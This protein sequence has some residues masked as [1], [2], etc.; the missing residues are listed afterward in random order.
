MNPTAYLAKIINQE[1]HQLWNWLPAIFAFGVIFYINLQ[2][3]FLDHV[4][5][6]LAIF[7]TSAILAYLNRA[8]YRSF[9]FLSL[10]LFL[11]A[12][13]YSNFY[14]KIFL[15]HTEISGKAYVDGI[16]KVEEIN[17]FYNPVSHLTGASLL[18]KDPVLY[19]MQFGEKKVEKP[20]IIKKKKFTS[21][22]KKKFSKTIH[23]KYAN[24]NGYQDLDRK[25]F[26]FSTNYQN[27][28]WVDSKGRK[29]FPNPPKKLLINIVKY[30]DDIKINDVIALKLSLNPS[31]KGEFPDDF[32]F[33]L[34]A[35]AKQI[36]GYG[37]GF[38][39]IKIV[40]KAEISSLDEFFISLRQSAKDKIF[41]ATDGD[42]AA[43]ISALLIGDQKDISLTLMKDIRGSGLAHLL[44]ISGFHLSLMAM[45]FLVGARFLLSRSEYLALNFDLKKISAIGAI[46]TTYFYLKIS[47]SPLPAQRS[48]L[49][50]LFF[51]ISIFV[52]QKLN[53]KRTIMAALFLMI[54]A[55]PYNIFNVGFQL[56][57]A[58]IL[59]LGAFSD[60]FGFLIK[61]E[62]DQSF[63]SKAFYYFITIVLTSIAIQIATTPFLM[64][65][66]KN[67]SVLGFIANIL[68]IPLASF[69]VM[70]VGFL[71]L[72]LMPFSLEKYVLILMKQG[73]VLIAKISTFVANLDY[74]YFISPQLSGIGL[75]LAVAGLFMIC[76]SESQL[77]FWGIAIFLS[78]FLTLSFAQKPDISFQ[79]KQKFFTIYDEKNGLIF[80]KDL[81]PSKNRDL[82]LKYF[83]QK[84]FKSYTDLTLEEKK[85]RGIFCKKESC[86]AEIKGKIFL[87]LLERTKVSEICVNNFDIIVNLTSKYELPTCVKDDKMKIDNLNFYQNGGQF[88]YFRNGGF[89]VK[90]S[91]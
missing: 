84:D 72:F 19:Q 69:F 88:F 31:R 64:Y 40:K 33:D 24:I 13:F 7:F 37:Y 44:S 17:K 30:A 2:Q 63:L 48:F 59:V 68:A 15:N 75:V 43:I 50:V 57:F 62:P 61:K 91:Y 38:G 8:S 85:E 26:D 89:E 5:I 41:K 90:S 29:Q 20:K 83:N 32:N 4:L 25:F 79:S 58:A 52:S 34:N 60:N 81:R 35:K 22:K 23:K 49:M 39:E 71:A 14:Q 82:W 66:F 65:S 21:R 56:S 11:F 46:I 53:A 16:A 76:L 86:T 87:I 78:A 28:Q 80:S 18:L 27:V 67:V 1:R 55:N 73:V 45:I 70:P 6:L 42:N 9:V 10:A 12:G 51:L 3:Q 47:G 74:S 77:K 36:G 54:L